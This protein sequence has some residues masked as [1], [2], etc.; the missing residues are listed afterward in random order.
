MNV[1]LP[2]TGI[3]GLFY[4]LLAMLMP[5]NHLWKVVRGRS[6]HATWTAPAIH[7]ATAIAILAAL[8][9]EGWLFQKTIVWA[10]KLHGVQGFFAYFATHRQIIPDNAHLVALASVM[11][12]GLVLLLVHGAGTYLGLREARAVKAE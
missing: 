11:T 7:S 4:L 5:L 8:Y 6:S 9:G 1:G 10:S 3:G 12:L 2:G